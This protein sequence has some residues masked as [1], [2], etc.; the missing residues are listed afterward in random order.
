MDDIDTE[1][2]A[3]MEL[4]EGD[5]PENEATSGKWIR[6]SIPEKDPTKDSVVFQQIDLDYYVGKF[7]FHNLDLNVLIFK[8]VI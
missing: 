7:I 8:S 6:P 5:G 1:R 3:D 2:K 4:A